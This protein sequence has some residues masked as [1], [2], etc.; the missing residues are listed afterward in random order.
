MSSF[1]PTLLYPSTAGGGRFLQLVDVENLVGG[2]TFCVA[3]A[4]AVRNAFE[5][6]APC[7]TVNQVVLATSHRAAASAWFA[8]P[9]SA[10]PLLRSGVDGADLALLQV[11]ATEQVEQRYDRVVIGSGDG[12]FAFPAARLQAAGCAVTVVTRPEALSRQLRLA[13]RDIRLI[14]IEATSE[15]AGSVA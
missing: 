6:A 14:Q 10:R 8:W 1:Q 3:D 12:I 4:A 11:L 15:T 9:A 5:S 7:G 13:V 2:A